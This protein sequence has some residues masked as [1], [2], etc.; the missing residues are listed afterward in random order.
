[1]ARWATAR[2]AAWAG[3]FVGLACGGVEPGSDGRP[4]IDRLEF[5]QQ[6]PTEPLRLEFGL[7]FTD[8]DGDV[9]QGQLEL[10]IGGMDQPPADLSSLFEAQVPPLAPDATEG[11]IELEVRLAGEVSPGDRLQL[12][13][14]LVD[15]GGRPSNRASVVL[16]AV[17]PQVDPREGA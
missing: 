7:R 14:R 10:Q 6:V 8:M 1:M 2:G 4:R 16:Q 9:G 3:L 17:G 12:G 15:G 11:F 5:F 13:F